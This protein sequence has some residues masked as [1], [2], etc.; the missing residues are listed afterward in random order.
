MKQ[1]LLFLHCVGFAITIGAALYDRFYVVRNIRRARGSLLERELIRI[2][3]STSPLFS[4]GVAL[5]LVSGIGLTL[6]H[7]E[8]FFQPS[9]LGLKQFLFLAIGLMFPVYITPSMR[10]IKHLLN[11]G[12]SESVDGPA[13]YRVLLNRLCWVLDGITATNMV[14]LAIAV[15][16][17]NLH[18]LMK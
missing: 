13:Q 4:V 11:L 17:P 3:L 2:Y 6:M 14:I 12:P 15:W 9:A 1:L 10:K 18:S 8:G 7:G 16:K 5:I